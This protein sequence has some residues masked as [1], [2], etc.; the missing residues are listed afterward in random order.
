MA[1]ID[2]IQHI[3][4]LQKALRGHSAGKMFGFRGRGQ[5]FVPEAELAVAGGIGVPRRGGSKHLSEPRAAEDE[6][7]ERDHDGRIGCL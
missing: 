4:E 6:R 1:S 5:I 7:S 3:L 2:R